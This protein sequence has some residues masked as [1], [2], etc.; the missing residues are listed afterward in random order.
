MKKART[1]A[2]SAS[3]RSR[4]KKS[5]LREFIS[6]SVVTLSLFLGVHTH[7]RSGR[8]HTAHTRVNGRFLSA[9]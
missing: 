1:L 2:R 4:R 9:V 7:T 6:R 5:G 3:T 8:S